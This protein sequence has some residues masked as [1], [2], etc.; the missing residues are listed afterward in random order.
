[1]TS[2]E[3]IGTTKFGVTHNV[4][5]VANTIPSN[6]FNPTVTPDKMVD[7]C[8]HYLTPSGRDVACPCRDRF[9]SCTG[10]PLDYR[11]IL[12]SRYRHLD[13]VIFGVKVSYSEEYDS[14][15]FKRFF[16][17]AEWNYRPKKPNS[18]RYVYGKLVLENH[19]MWDAIRSIINDRDGYV[20]G[21][22]PCKLC[23]K[24]C[25][26]GSEEPCRGK[27][28][29]FALERVGLNVGEIVEKYLDF[30]LNWLDPTG[31]TRPNYLCSIAMAFM[32]NG[33]SEKYIID[34]VVSS[35]RSKIK[36]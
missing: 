30:E 2:A 33:N 34:K 4:T 13:P 23:H 25:A 3:V 18:T 16:G 11:K 36:R 8:S 32:Y 27:Q 24:R 29:V 9:Y 1:M 28:I 7:L 19:S 17:L 35:I 31:N 20:F 10:G 12:P 6:E 22:G 15:F 14:D 5:V 21:F 26:L